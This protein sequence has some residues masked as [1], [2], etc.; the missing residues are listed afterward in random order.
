[1]AFRHNA[2]TWIDAHC[3]LADPRFDRD[4]EEVVA[5]SRR[6]GVTAWV[7]GGVGPEDWTWQDKIAETLG[8]GLLRCFGLHPWWV[9]ERAPEEINAGLKTLGERLDSARAIGEAGLDKGKRGRWEH[10]AKRQM[11]ALLSQAQLAH[12]FGK[13]LVL[14]V[15]GAHAEAL[16]ILEKIGKVPPGPGPFLQRSAL[17]GNATPPS[18]S[19]S[20]G[21]SLAEPGD[22]GA[23]APW[24]PRP[25]TAALETDS[26][27]A[28]GGLA[29]RAQPPPGGGRRRGAIRGR[30][31][32]ASWTSAGTISSGFSSSHENPTPAPQNRGAAERRG[33]FRLP[34]SSAFDR[35]A[36]LVGRGAMEKLLR[37]HV[38]GAGLGGV[39]S[40]AAEA[41]ARAGVGR[42]TLV[43]FDA[44]CVTNANRQLHALDE[45]VGRPKASVMAARLRQVNPRA[46]VR[47]VARFLDQAALPELFREKPDFV[48]DAIDSVASKCQLLA[49]CKEH[50][51]PVVTSTGSGGRLD[52]T[53]V[54]VA[55]LSKT[56]SDPLARDIRRILREKHGFPK[57][58]GAAFGIPA[59]FS[60]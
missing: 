36:G 55:D 16:E 38:L 35:M 21:F 48:I 56:Q 3:H 7:Q 28:P 9:A 23:V 11:N 43:D 47:A 27:T 31:A 17:Q 39:G 52:P 8:D 19:A 30:P 53:Q 33:A 54:R 50:A 5:R 25:P 18:V 42:L 4:R 49:Y 15:V 58:E 13:P 40:W 26:R 14:H 10:S 12:L 37:S 46:E 20:F 1:M 24:R 41:A 51:V 57:K 22:G 32:K 2:G 59:V 45:T 29:Q 44:V 60:A 6:A 34:A